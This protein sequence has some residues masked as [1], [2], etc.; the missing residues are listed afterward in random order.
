[1]KKVL[2]PISLNRISRNA[3]AAGREQGGGGAPCVRERVS[4]D[5]VER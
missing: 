5:D 2:S 1:M 3:W 4:D